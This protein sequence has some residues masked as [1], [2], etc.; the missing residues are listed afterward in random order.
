MAIET[1]T[2]A[3]VPP[4]TTWRR[5][6]GETEAH[7]FSVGPGWTRSACRS[8]AWSAALMVDDHAPKCSECLGILTPTEAELRAMDGNR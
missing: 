7:A 8:R 6:A 4:N 1:G 5:G 3:Y 2:P